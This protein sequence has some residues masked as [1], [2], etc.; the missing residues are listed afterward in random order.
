MV[1]GD[2]NVMVDLIGGESPQMNLLW[3]FVLTK[4]ADDQSKVEIVLQGS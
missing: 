2:E 1:D 3:E 4:L